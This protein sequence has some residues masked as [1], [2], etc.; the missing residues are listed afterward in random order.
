MVKA[1]ILVCSFPRR[2]HDHKLFI[3]NFIAAGSPPFVSLYSFVYFRKR[4]GVTLSFCVNNNISFALCTPIS[5]FTLAYPT[6]RLACQ[7]QMCF[8]V[9]WRLACGSVC[10][11]ATCKKMAVCASVLQ[12]KDAN[13]QAQPV[14]SQ[15]RWRETNSSKSFELH[16]SQV[17]KEKSLLTIKMVGFVVSINWPDRMEELYALCV[18]KWIVL[19]VN[20]HYSIFTNTDRMFEYLAGYLST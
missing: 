14:K 8:C 5:Y 15:C 20:R 11:C 2:G 16:K 17:T 19:N 7:S 6:G 4:R 18:F 3:S 9:R 13:L 1:Q 12:C 10:M